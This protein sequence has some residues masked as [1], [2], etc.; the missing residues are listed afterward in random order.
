MYPPINEQ[1]AYDYPGLH[2]VS[3]LAGE[4]GLWLPSANQLTDEEINI[5]CEEINE[6]YT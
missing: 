5:I 6:F 2:P 4:K 3:I 1:K